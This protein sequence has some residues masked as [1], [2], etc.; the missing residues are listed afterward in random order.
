M[1]KVYPSMLSSDFA[2]LR[3]EIRALEL[4]QA[5]AVH[6]DVMDGS[7]VDAITFGAQV[8][9]ACRSLTNL[10][11]DVHLMVNN[12]AKHIPAML[13]AGADTIIVHAES[14]PHLHK[15][16]T[17]IKEQGKNAG[18]AFNP[19]T[20]VDCLQYLEGLVDFVL[21][22][23]VNPGASAQAFIPSPLNKIT[24]IRALTNAEICLDGGIN[25]NSIA[26]C[27]AA[28]SVVSGSFI[29]RHN[30]YAIPIKQLRTLW[31]NAQCAYQS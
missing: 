11:F 12:P 14:D 30:D 29:F 17:S 26:L 3:D 19:A 2:N 13:K 9:A 20:S 31:E 7:F 21:L 18:V 15:L 25:D 1:L 28:D 8:I 5:D 24:Q 6:W 4:A 23:T 27:R 10:R 22:M 16:L